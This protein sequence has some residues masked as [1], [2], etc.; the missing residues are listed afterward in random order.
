V[1]ISA[2]APQGRA[3]IGVPQAIASI[4]ARPNGSGQS[5]VNSRAIAL[6][7]N[8]LFSDSPISPIYSTSGGDSRGLITASK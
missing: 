1:T 5:I 8:S 3:I 7:R 6:P 4:I 2:T